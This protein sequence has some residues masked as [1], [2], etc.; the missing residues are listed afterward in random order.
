M[1]DHTSQEKYVPFLQMN[2]VCA[3]TI[4]RNDSLDHLAWYTCTV[5]L[6]EVT[7]HVLVWFVETELVPVVLPISFRLTAP[8]RGLSDDCAT[9]S[10]ATLKDEGNLY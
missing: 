6:L 7:T 1:F 4:E 5:F 9:A 3:T 10:E 2:T 8:P